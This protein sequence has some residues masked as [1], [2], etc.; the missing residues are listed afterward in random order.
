MPYL[1]ATPETEGPY[2]LTAWMSSLERAKALRYGALMVVLAKT[3]WWLLVATAVLIAVPHVN[4]WIS[5]PAAL[6]VLA[7]AF[8]LWGD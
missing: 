6:F 4:E 2:R 7:G 1:F 8:A 3:M 5:V